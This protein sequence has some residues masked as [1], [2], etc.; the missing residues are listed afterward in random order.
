LEGAKYVECEFV[1]IILHS[2]FAASGE[3]KRWKQR[4]IRTNSLKS[5]DRRRQQRQVPAPGQPRSN[6]ILTGEIFA[7]PHS[8]HIPNNIFNM[9]P[10]S[11]D[12]ARKYQ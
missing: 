12:K 6:G 2:I 1:A 3:D 5:I 9:L 7:A 11:V 10:F 4:K 8:A